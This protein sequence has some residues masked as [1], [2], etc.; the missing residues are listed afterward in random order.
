MKGI[1]NLSMTLFALIL[2]GCGADSRGIMLQGED[3]TYLIR[4][5]QSDGQNVYHYQSGGRGTYQLSHRWVVSYRASENTPK[6]A[7][8][9]DILSMDMKHNRSHWSSL[10]TPSEDL[11][12]P[13]LMREGF[14]LSVD[15]TGVASL[16]AKNP[17]LWQAAEDKA[18]KDFAST[19]TK[20]LTI[21][22][23]IRG[24]P[25]RVGATVELNTFYRGQPAILEVIAVWPE[26]FEVQI[27]LS[28]NEDMFATAVI[29]RQSERIEWLSM[30][31]I[32]PFNL[33]GNMLVAR[34]LL[35]MTP[36]EQARD[37][38]MLSDDH[39]AIGWL[40]KDGDK[41][42]PIERLPEDVPSP[43]PDDKGLAFDVGHFEW[44][45]K[46]ELTL[47]LPLANN[48]T[49]G[50]GETRFRDLKARTESG[51]L[52]PLSVI[53][54]EGFWHEPIDAG[55][56]AEKNALV[57][58]WDAEAQLEQ[59]ETISGVVD[60]YPPTPIQTF[61]I[62][63]PKERSETFNLGDAVVSVRYHPEEGF[64]SIGLE[65]PEVATLYPFFG[66][67]EGEYDYMDS[68]VEPDWLTAGETAWMDIAPSR[69]QL[70]L[71]KSPGDVVDLWISMKS[72]TPSETREVEWKLRK[73]E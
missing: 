5:Y 6:A 35:V 9:V 70:K 26:T 52:V 15:K 68:R 3:A 72:T 38:V 24:V 48:D 41:W 49:A 16:V 45:S 40:E 7:L 55:Y 17:A 61:S 67:L 47:S 11:V 69:Y 59:I 2:M 64:Y 46:S 62:R 22:G 14:T 33:R 18:G 13:G 65:N 20:G 1:R 60:L 50:G 42:M 43:K 8:D 10:S 39:V 25:Q 30:V 63:W 21:P 32:E 56:Q 58:G 53:S 44:A 19:L 29:D 71:S 23:V 12:G 36:L 57:L 66:G 73:D 51:S 37:F 54:D 31:S 28:S 34:S 4:Y 27:R